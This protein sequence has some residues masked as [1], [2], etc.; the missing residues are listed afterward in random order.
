MDYEFEFVLFRRVS[1]KIS[2]SILLE[3]QN[4]CALVRM[5]NNSKTDEFSEKGIIFN[6]K[7]CIADF[8]HYRRYFSHEFRKKI[9]I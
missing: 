2:L 1:F 9:A 4:V 3:C 5:P 6:P 8:C 7:I